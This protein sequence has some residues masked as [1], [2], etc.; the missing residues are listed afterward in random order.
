MG[1]KT[2]TKAEKTAKIEEAIL[3]QKQF[4][5][6]EIRK[7]NKDEEPFPFEK[8]RRLERC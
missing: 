2:L 7:L 1:A 8:W 3:I 5:E 4:K 6:Y